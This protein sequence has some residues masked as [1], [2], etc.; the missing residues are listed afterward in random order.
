[1]NKHYAEHHTFVLER[2]YS[3]LPTDVFAAW[4]DPVAKSHWF[5]KA[6]KFEFRVGGHELHHGGSLGGPIYTFDARY[7]EIVH[8]HRIVY[9]YIMDMEKPTVAVGKKRISA[10][11]CTIEFKAEGTGTHLVYTEQAVFLDGHDTPELRKQGTQA[12]LDKLG[13]HLKSG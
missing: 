5:P 2:H 10:S 1:M 13:V 6:D 12:F 8:D 7:E 4:A 9:S 11:L 3:A